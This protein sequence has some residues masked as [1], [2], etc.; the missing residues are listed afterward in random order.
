MSCNR[1]QGNMAGRDNMDCIR[2]P[3]VI[4]E[5]WHLDRSVQKMYSLNFNPLKIGI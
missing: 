5:K 2:G 3:I 1:V 4:R